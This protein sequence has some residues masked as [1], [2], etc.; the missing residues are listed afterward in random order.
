MKK[1][2][3]IALI[4]SNVMVVVF[5]FSLLVTNFSAEQVMVFNQLFGGPTSELVSAEGEETDSIYYKTW[6][7]SV[8]D[9]MNGNDAVSAAIMAEGSVLLKNDNN[10]LPLADQ[11][12]VSLFGV[13]AYDPIYSMN[14]GATKVTPN[15]D[16]K[17]YYKGV[18]EEAGL[19]VNSDISAW[20]QT[21][22]GKYF[23]TPAAGNATFPVL[24]DAPWADI[25][26]AGILP[27]NDGGTAMFVFGR[28]GNEGGDIPFAGDGYGST[29]NY[30]ELTATE[31][32]VLQGMKD[33]KAAG[34]YSKTVVIINSTNVMQEDF[35]KIFEDY[36]VDAA[37]WIGTPGTG[38]LKGVASVITGKSNPSGKL[39]DMWYSSTKNNPSAPNYMSTKTADHDHTY[40]LYQEGVY[41]GY[42]YAETRYEDV[43]LKSNNAGAYDYSTQVSYPFGHGLSYT[44]FKYSDLDV[45]LPSNQDG[46]YKVKVKVTN[47]GS[48][49]GKETVQ[50]Y[51][52]KPYTAYDVEN[53]IE[54]PSA[55]LVGYGKTKKLAIG[56]SETL[57]ISV[58]ANQL[59][60]DFDSYGKG[61][62]VLQQ[63][64][65]YL[66]T[67]RDSH[68]ATNNF[69]AAK[70]HT[71]GSS[72]GKMDKNGDSS[73]TKK[74]TI[75]EDTENNYKYESNT[76]TEVTRLFDHADPNRVDPG[77]TP[78]TFMSRNDWSNTVFTT[79][80]TVASSTKRD[81][82]RAYD[83][84]KMVQKD[85]KALYPVYGD[86][87][88]S[89]YIPLIS[90]RLNEA[91]EPIP[92]NDPKWETFL[93]QLSWEE[94]VYMISNGWRTTPA[95]SSVSKPALSSPNG[96]LGFNWKYNY[97]AGEK[98]QLPGFAGK[99][100]DPDQDS[101]CVGYPHHSIIASTFNTELAYAVGQAYGEDSLWAGFAG[102]FGFGLNLHRNPYGGRNGEYFSD[103]AF[104]SGITA[105]WMS[106]GIQS[107]G[108]HVYN[109]HFALNDMDHNRT[110][111]YET[112]IT[113]Q[114]IRQHY[115]KVYEL[116]IDVGDA[117]NVM[118]SFTRIGS[119]VACSNENLLTKY[120]RDE[121]GM[122][123][124]SI[125][126]GGYSQSYGMGMVQG[127][128][129]GNDLPDG[130]LGGIKLNDDNS[131][132]ISEKHEFFGMGPNDGGYGHVG[133]ALRE[134]VHRIMY[135]TAW[136]NAMNYFDSNTRIIT[137]PAAWVAVVDGIMI[138]TT[139]LFILSLA[140]LGTV[141]AFEIVKK[142]KKSKSQ[143]TK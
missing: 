83:N 20:Y 94:S 111:P 26:S 126:D 142:V 5:G 68:N 129:A 127:V 61:T 44:D 140:G 89:G 39:S 41:V 18:L 23:H 98:Y 14:G 69:L 58:N 97:I 21:N 134:S 34:K 17:Q 137:H 57:E 37:L 52:Q 132:T 79:R 19:N 105:G 4:V 139:V 87:P 99:T 80:T 128:L 135:I 59:F 64:D 73:L 56:T 74:I 103:D 15:E 60:S 38:G 70:G 36:D 138:T 113:E 22:S 84:S 46:I 35:P 108:C 124:Y 77:A 27:S 63:G 10:A 6:Y 43:V 141:Y 47:Q 88:E 49:A 78:V 45:E 28:V 125:T 75:S 81:E 30:L 121:C 48:A 82:E 123:G 55:E 42:R 118:I 2:K 62:Y 106:K 29:T 114:T 51:L 12:K 25:E 50:V 112:W 3:L 66:T 136:S 130:T 1:S 120:L 53:K 122:K 24:K 91:G 110:S 86:V 115:L 100:N 54:K 143:G 85:P 65:Y 33:V 11:S 32:T 72:E 131:I 104:L 109:K 92:Y 102:I 71:V 107:K 7:N 119:R 40:V 101:R 9:V 76:G 116:A 90:M 133:Q 67:A 96:P 31:K 117:S 13:T 8:S 16:R 93:D 95:L